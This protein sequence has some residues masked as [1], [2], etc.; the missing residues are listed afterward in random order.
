MKDVPIFQDVRVHKHLPKD[1]DALKNRDVPN[2]IY[3]RFLSSNS[4]YLSKSHGLIQSVFKIV[5]YCIHFFITWGWLYPVSVPIPNNGPHSD[6]SSLNGSNRTITG[7]SLKVHTFIFNRGVLTPLILE[8]SL[9]SLDVN[10]P[11]WFM[12]SSNQPTS[13]LKK[14]RIWKSLF[15][16][17]I[18][19]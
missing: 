2:S 6:L 12:R 9:A 16:L 13:C 5:N 4:I 14:F 1:P 11:T 10:V 3:H 17:N 18:S 15:C 19:D 8:A 7:Y